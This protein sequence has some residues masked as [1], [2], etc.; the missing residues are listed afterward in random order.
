MDAFVLLKQ[1]EAE[2]DSLDSTIKVLRAHLG[3]SQSHAKAPGSP[4]AHG[5]VWTPARRA[6]MS[7][8]MKSRIAAKKEKAAS[9]TKKKP[10]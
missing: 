3:G 9:A 6:A 1:L 4:K 8:L 10:G 7:K 2:R 5:S